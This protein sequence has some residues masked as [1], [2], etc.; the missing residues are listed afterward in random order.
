MEIKKGIGVSPGVVVSTAIVLDAEDLL[1]PKRQVDV[2]QLPAEVERFYAALRQATHDLT[3]QREDVTAKYGDEIGGIFG[4]HLGLLADKTILKQVVA[5]IT[6]RHSTAEYAVSTVMR[7]YANAFLAMADKYMSDRVKDIYDIER[8]ILHNLIGQ[9]HEDLSHLTR[10]VVVIAHDLLP[11]Q[12]AAL[13]RVHVRGFATDVG[14]RTSHT[15]IV[16]RAMGIPAVVGLGSITSEVS[17]GD[18][19]IIDGNRGVVIVNPDAEQLAEHAEFQKKL[20]RLDAELRAL[21]DLP[22]VTLDGHEVCLQANIESPE[23]VTESL[24]RGAQG[25]GLYRTEF[26]YLTSE[27]PPEAEDHYHAYAA[28]L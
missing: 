15:A 25:I 18:M 12:T 23:D 24:T 10:D 22:A 26:L 16:A 13:D 4:V 3:K 9:K 14:G 8:R 7:K 2:D 11:S 5:E 21:A 6:E 1:I 20:V 27:T 17:G 19:V 28:V